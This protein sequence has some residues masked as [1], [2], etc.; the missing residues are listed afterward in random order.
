[1][2][3]EKA[4]LKPSFST[5]TDESLDIENPSSGSFE[6]SSKRKKKLLHK[7]HHHPKKYLGHNY[8]LLWG[9]KDPIL[10]IGPHW[11]LFLCMWTLLVGEHYLL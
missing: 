1:M 8:P 9:K 7:H 2:S 5:T 11:P 3:T 6:V 10:T 4:Q